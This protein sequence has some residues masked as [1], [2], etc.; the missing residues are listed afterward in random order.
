M[1]TVTFHLRFFLLVVTIEE[2][3]QKM[4]FIKN[5]LEKTVVSNILDNMLTF[6]QSARN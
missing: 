4:S 6:T 5:F 3:Q 1:F 2:G